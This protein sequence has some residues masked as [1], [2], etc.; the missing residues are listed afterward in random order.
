M[1]AW[2][3]SAQTASAQTV[4]A[5]LVPGLQYVDSLIAA[6]FARDSTGSITAGIVQRDQLVWTG[7]YGFANMATRQPANRQT[8]YRIGSITKMFTATML[9]Q[10][11][12]SGR[13]KLSDPVVRHYPTFA[14]IPGAGK[15]ESP[16][17]LWQLATMTSGLSAEVRNGAAFDTGAAAQ[18]EAT[19]QRALSNAAFI[20][21]PGTHFQ[22][23][24]IGYAILGA[25]LS[26]A[27]SMP[28]IAWQEQRILA[29]LGMTRSHFALSSDIAGD[30]ATGYVVENGR[31]DSTLPMREVRQGRGYRVPN[32]GLF[33]TVD[34]LGRFLSF[35]LGHGPASVLPRARLDSAYVGMVATSTEE[36]FGYGLG[37]MLQRRGDFPWVGHSGG[38]PG[39]QAVMYFDRDHQLGV[40][41]LRN[42]TG[43]RVSINRLGPDLLK[44]LILEK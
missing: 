44:M 42:A 18:W 3:V 25:A 4:A 20:A 10:L 17:T 8:V 19:L 14:Q 15:T 7:S 31:A 12:Q 27:A 33:T 26:R 22:Y 34:D 6:E 2:E 41:L 9:M 28:Y 32:G 16:V 11:A 43:G 35:Q 1:S 5:P 23:S 36:D 30:L 13:V 39:Y 24:N 40:I 29:P 21:S 38:T 37:F